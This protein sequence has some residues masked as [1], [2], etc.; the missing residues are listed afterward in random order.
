MF[1]LVFSVNLNTLMVFKSLT[2]TDPLG[3]QIGGLSCRFNKVYREMFGFIF[4]CAG[5]Y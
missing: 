1:F 5:E 2:N 3:S 4:Y